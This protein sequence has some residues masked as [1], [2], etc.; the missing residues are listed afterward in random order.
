MKPAGDDRLTALPEPMDTCAE[1]ETPE[2]VRFRYQLAGPARR[3]LAWGIDGVLRA[4]IVLGFALIATMGGVAVGDSFGEASMGLVLLVAFVVEWG[5]FVVFEMTS[6]GR[7]PGKR[8]ARIRVVTQGGHPLRL[9]DSML[10][11]LLRAA[12]FL[13][14]GYALGVVAMARDRHFRRLGDLVAGTMVV[15]EDRRAVNEPIRIHPAPTASELDALPARVHLSG[16]EQEAIELFLRRAPSLGAA[17]VQELA[18][19][20]AP[21]YGKRFGVRYT[22]PARLLALL[23][24]R[25][26]ERGRS[27]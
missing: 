24:W 13:P 16:D 14:F 5:Y 17:R 9:G 12:D 6:S 2:H 8:A 19:L 7:T 27:A 11:N 3:A 22:D 10:R 1:V 23:Y 25:T 18:D 15:I 4:G 26:R 21:S 20:V